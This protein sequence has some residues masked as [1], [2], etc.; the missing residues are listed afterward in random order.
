MDFVE[1][2]R[3]ALIDTKTH[4]KNAIGQK[5]MNCVNFSLCYTYQYIF[6]YIASKQNANVNNTGA[7]TV[8][9]RSV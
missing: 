7:A 8:R 4:F 5:K 3:L 6:F 2:I 1:Q 9:M